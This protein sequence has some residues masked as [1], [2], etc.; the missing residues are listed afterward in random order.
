MKAKACS[1]EVRPLVLGNMSRIIMFI[2]GMAKA[3]ATQ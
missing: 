2:A 3:M 1:D